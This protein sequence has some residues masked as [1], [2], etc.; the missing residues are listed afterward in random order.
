M[1]THHDMN[2]S[3]YKKWW[4]LIKGL[5]P[6][7]VL[8]VDNVPYHNKQ[9][10]KFSISVSRKGEIKEWQM[11]TNIKFVHFMLEPELYSLIKT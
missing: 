6:H 8:I 2:Y 7:S 5:T 10:D 11:V 4:K 1:I 3:N 9:I